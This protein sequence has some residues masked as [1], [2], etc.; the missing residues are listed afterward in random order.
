MDWR[1]IVVDGSG[2]REGSSFLT[3]LCRRDPVSVIIQH[4]P[5]GGE[6][7]GLIGSSG[8]DLHVKI[9]ARAGR[10]SGPQCSAKT[11][12]SR[13]RVRYLGHSLAGLQ[14]CAE[15]HS[16]ESREPSA[17]SCTPRRVSVSH[18]LRRMVIR[19]PSWI[20]HLE[21]QLRSITTSSCYFNTTLLFVVPVPGGQSLAGPISAFGGRHRERGSSRLYFIGVFPGD[22][23]PTF[24]QHI[25][26]TPRCRS[27]PAFPV[28]SH[29]ARFRSRL[30][31]PSE[32]ST[33][34]SR[35]QARTLGASGPRRPCQDRRRH[36]VRGPVR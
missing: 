30:R 8:S 29:N 7:R 6:N 5:H 16:G 33:A 25:P 1:A 20:C 3:S 17:N 32:T 9:V 4:A 24:S 36:R 26:E 28:D 19:Y 27:P 15:A 35:R 11:V 10:E 31:G 23:R 2:S 22:T 12:K 14:Q 34:A 21:S 13:V 18:E